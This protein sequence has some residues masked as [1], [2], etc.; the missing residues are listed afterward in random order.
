M[1]DWATALNVN[2]DRFDPGVSLGAARS[3]LEGLTRSLLD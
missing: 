2:L 1:I 3:V